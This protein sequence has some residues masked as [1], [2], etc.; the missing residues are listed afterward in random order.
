MKS[1]FYK[2]A[3]SISNVTIF[4]ILF[5]GIS[6]AT[7]YENEHQHYLGIKGAMARDRYSV[8]ALDILEFE[9]RYPNSDYLCELLP[10]HIAW[11]KD[12]NLNSKDI[13]TKYDK[14]CVKK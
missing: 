1:F 4:S 10:I 3:S 9:K 7:T 14:K 2:I 11:K 6:C 5:L 12:K 8:A 13:E